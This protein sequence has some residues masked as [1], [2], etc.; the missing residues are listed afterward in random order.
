MQTAVMQCT[1][2]ARQGK[3]TKVCCRVCRETGRAVVVRLL[4]L[5]SF[6]WHSWQSWVAGRDAPLWP[7]GG[8]G[9]QLD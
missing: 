7:A 9:D 4:G 5:F 3:A 8:N 1:S 2:K 6:G